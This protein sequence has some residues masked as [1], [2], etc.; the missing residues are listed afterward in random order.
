LANR[1]I[2][3]RQITHQV[4]LATVHYAYVE[5]I[6]FGTLCIYAIAT[7]TFAVFHTC[8]INFTVANVIETIAYAARPMSYP[9]AIG[10]AVAGR[11]NFGAF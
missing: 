5:R 6:S 10:V 9:T 2:V 1:Y 8:S 4:G 3:R 7:A 11:P